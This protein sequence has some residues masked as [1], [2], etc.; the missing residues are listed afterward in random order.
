MLCVICA[1][2]CVGWTASRAGVTSDPHYI[3]SLV[4]PN[5]HYKGNPSIVRYPHYRGIYIVP[6]DFTRTISDTRTI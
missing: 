6:N 3:G 4:E 2:F 1:C 5:P